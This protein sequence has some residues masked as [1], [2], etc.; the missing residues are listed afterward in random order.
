MYS[1]CLPQLGDLD[2]IFVTQGMAN[3]SRERDEP[4]NVNISGILGSDIVGCLAALG[5][6]NTSF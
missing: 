3:G 1:F 6:Q 5:F 4:R 2:Q